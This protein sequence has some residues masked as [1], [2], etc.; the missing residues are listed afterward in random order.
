M[1]TLIN[2]NH[3]IIILLIYFCF[4]SGFSVNAQY[5]EKVLE[6][7]RLDVGLIESR[8]NTGSIQKFAKAWNQTNQRLDLQSPYCGLSLWY[9]YT[10]AGINPNIPFSPRAINWY[11]NCK[12]PKSFAL[13]SIKDLSELKPSGA[14]VFKNSWGN[15]VGL[16]E[17]AIGF[18]IFTI[19][20]NTS[21]ARSIKKYNLKAEGVFYL[22]TRIDNK[23]LKPIYYCDCVEQGSIISN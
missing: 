12:K 16:F 8:N 21:N 14:V 10:K 23:S 5:R 9:W 11:K 1:E 4:G 13:M 3:K 7:A 22:K 6:T 19:E 20:G 18:E 2:H 15:H 17:K